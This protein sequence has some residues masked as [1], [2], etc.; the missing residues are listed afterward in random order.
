MEGGTRVPPATNESAIV[1]TLYTDAFAPAVATLGHSLKQTNTSARLI[2]LYLPDRISHEALCVAT[3]SGFTP[4]PVSRIPPP[5]NGAGVHRHFLDQYT[6]LTLWT[7][8]EIGI[9]SLV[10]LDADT[11]VR[12]NI[13]ELFTFPFNF[14]A[15]PDV[16][17]DSRGFTIGFNAGVM[18]LRP[19][20]TV[21][22]TMI[23]QIATANYPFEDAEQSF[24]NYFYSAE[25]LRLPYAYNGNLAIK[26]R[27]PTLWEGIV[28]ELR[29]V[30]YTM[31]KPFLGYDYSQINIEDMDDHVDWMARRRGGYYREEVKWWGEAWKDMKATY[32]SQ[33]AE[34]TPSRR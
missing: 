7:L 9:K 29:I 5:N 11:L 18:F 20:S 19:S 22:Q 26:K 32:H 30:H 27:T 4:R 10:Y 33:L 3:A 23:S 15:V 17:L 34:C 28:D 8:D 6:K 24:L 12:K 21:F 2:L 13:D 1:T 16:Y 25:A 14:A 31:V